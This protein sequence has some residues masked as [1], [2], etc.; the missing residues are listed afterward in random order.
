[1][2]IAHQSKIHRKAESENKST[3]MLIYLSVDS[4]SGK[5]LEATK[6]NGTV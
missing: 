1:M 5:A 6:R 3:V 4:F 2:I